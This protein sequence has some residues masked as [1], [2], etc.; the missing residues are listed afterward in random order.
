M[1]TENLV[2]L[3]FKDPNLWHSQDAPIDLKQLPNYYLML[4][5]SRL[6]MLVCI[7]SAAGHNAIFE[8]FVNYF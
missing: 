6:T 3:D 7:T 5:K 4:S 2:K 1:K 8:E